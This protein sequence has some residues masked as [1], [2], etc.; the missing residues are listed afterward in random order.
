MKLTINGMNEYFSAYQIG[1]RKMLKATKATRDQIKDL[2]RAI[3]L[4]ENLIVKEVR[5]ND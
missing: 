2:E 1:K 3:E 5:K 4:N